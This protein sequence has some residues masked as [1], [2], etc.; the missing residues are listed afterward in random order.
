MPDLA[1]LF[2]HLDQKQASCVYWLAALPG[3]HYQDSTVFGTQVPYIR[4]QTQPDQLTVS[5]QG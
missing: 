1:A 3:I 2:L 5:M 4:G